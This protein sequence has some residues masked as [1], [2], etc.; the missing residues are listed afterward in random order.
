MHCLGLIEHFLAADVKHFLA[1]DVRG[2]V[3][4]Q[5]NES[6]ISHRVCWERNA[7]AILLCQSSQAY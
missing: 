7:V 4:D 6:P 2:H 5:S 1:A 3:C